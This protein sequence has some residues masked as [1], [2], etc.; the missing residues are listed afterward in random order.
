MLTDT[1]CNLANQAMNQHGRLPEHRLEVSANT[2]PA[3]HS[4]VLFPKLGART[5][6]NSL[7]LKQRHHSQRLMCSYVDNF[8][9]VAQ[10]K[11]QQRRLLRA[12]LHAIDAVLRPLSAGDS[13][14]R[15]ESTTSVKKLQQGDAL[16][17]PETVPG[18]GLGHGDRH[19]LP[20]ATSV[21]TF[22]YPAGHGQACSKA[23][24]QCQL[25]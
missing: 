16:E 10:T 12:T 18:L 2:P 19:S 23:T 3:G 14:L 21:R 7:A 17:H 20:S 24:P 8:L 4:E 22:V 11:R 13:A 9:L 6:H 25:A 15:K 5:M 1:A